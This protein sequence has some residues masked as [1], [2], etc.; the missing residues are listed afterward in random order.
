MELKNSLNKYFYTLII[1]LF[2]C[3]FSNEV[4]AGTETC[5]TGLDTSYKTGDTTDVTVSFQG[6]TDF[7]NDGMID[8]QFDMDFDVSGATLSTCSFDGSAV[9]SININTLEVTRQS[10]GST[11]MAFMPNSCTFN[12]I[13]NPSYVQT[14]DSY[15]CNTYDNALFLL[16]SGTEAGSSITVNSLSATNV[17][18]ADLN[19]ASQGTVTVSFTTKNALSSSD[20]IKITFGSGFDLTS[21]GSSDGA[22]STMDGTIT[23]SVSSQVVTLTRGGGSTQSAAAETCTIANVINPTSGGSTGT[24]TIQTT[25]LANQ[26]RDQDI[27]VTADTILTCSNGTFFLS[28]L[29]DKLC[30]EEF[31]SRL[32]LASVL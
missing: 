26:A 4:L 29:D 31:Y 9:L 8:F 7:P 20:K 6:E 16:D 17:E 24:Y 27:S 32:I 21:V 10:D 22:C 28:S 5:T 11:V 18:P 1:L 19:P 15:N 3:F 23:T 30:G 25:T 12:G 13:V 14:T 2:F